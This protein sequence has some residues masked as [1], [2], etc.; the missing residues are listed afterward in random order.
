[1]LEAN[2]FNHAL[3]T[4]EEVAVRL[5]M[6]TG[7]NLKAF[8]ARKSAGSEARAGGGQKEAP[9]WQRLMAIRQPLLMIYGREDRGEAARRVEFAKQQFPALGLH[10]VPD[11][12]HLVQ[13]DAADA[14][15]RLAGP[16]LRQA[17]TLAG[18]TAASRGALAAS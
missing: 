14:F 6:S 7:K 3:I 18:A 8:Q 16:F 9:L 2:L 17:S 15:H 4:D 13:W 5:R 10:L 11:C 1:V 12:K